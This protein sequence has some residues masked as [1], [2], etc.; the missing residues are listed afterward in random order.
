MLATVAAVTEKVGV[1][2]VCP[3]KLAEMETVPNATPVASPSCVTV[4]TELLELDQL[5][6]LERFC[7]V[8]SEKVP[9][10]VNCSVVPSGTGFG[11]VGVIAMDVSTAAETAT[12]KLLVCPPAW[13]VMMLV[14]GRMPLTVPLELVVATVVLEELRVALLVRSCVVPSE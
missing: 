4:A 10:A 13:T 8:P 2:A 14:P 7:M 5:A 1:V 6:E 9:V 11:V 12:L 3:S